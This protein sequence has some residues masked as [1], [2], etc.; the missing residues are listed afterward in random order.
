MNLLHAILIVSAIVIAG[1][2]QPAPEQNH[3]QEQQ[4][5]Q[6][7]EMCAQVITPAISQDGTCIE[8]PTPCDVP[9]G[10]TLTQTCETNEMAS[11]Y[12]FDT[13]LLFCDYL[14]TESKYIL[15]YQIR[16]QSG[17]KP[18]DGHTIWISVPEKD[19]SQKKTLQGEYETNKILWEKSVFYYGSKNYRGQ[20]WEIRGE[21]NFSELEYN[22]IFCEGPELCLPEEGIILDSGTTTEKCTDT[23]NAE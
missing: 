4:Q 13:N 3:N 16:N 8:F 14:P 10:Y 22:L 5:E 9:D 1:C 2:T 21:D 11:A 15:F 20:N 17:E 23:G 18:L 12:S 7:E 19:Y 6:Q